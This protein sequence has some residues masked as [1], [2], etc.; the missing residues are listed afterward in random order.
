MHEAKAEHERTEKAAGSSPS[1]DYK[2]KKS[3]ARRARGRVA[4]A[5]YLDKAKTT[6]RGHFI[7]RR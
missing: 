5:E 3:W 2:T 1:E 7:G 6:L 4:K